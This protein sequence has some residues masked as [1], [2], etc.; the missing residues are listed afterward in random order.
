[1]RYCLF[2]L[3]LLLFVV[4]GLAGSGCKPSTSTDRQS[5][6]PPEAPNLLEESAGDLLEE[7]WAAHFIHGSK[8]GHRH[9]RVFRV[10]APDAPLLQIVSVDRLELRRF[11]N[12]VVQQLTTASLETDD[13]QIQALAYRL[14]DGKSVSQ[15]IGAVTSGHLVL[16]R[17]AHDADEK[18]RYVWSDEQRGIFAVQRS[19]RRQP[20]KPGEKRT[21][22]GFL[23]L[24]DQAVEFHL[25]ALTDESV[26]IGDERR[27]LLRIEAVDP[28]ADRWQIPTI[29]WADQSGRV[30]KQQEAFLNRE[31]V[32]VDEAEANRPND[33]VRVDLGVDGGVPV[34]SP[35]P[36]A[37]QV[38]Y[39][40][41]RVQVSGLTPQQ[42]FPTGLSQ[43]VLPAEEGV[44][45]VTVRQVLPDVPGVVDVDI[46]PPEPE[47]LAPNA[48]IQS[49]NPRIRAIADSV[50]GS[51]EDPWF[52]AQLL[53]HHVHGRLSKTDFSQVFSSAAEVAEQRRGDC[54]EHAVL[55]AAVC[56]ARQIPARVT[57]GLLYSADTR[58][59]LYHMWNEVWIKDRWIPLDA[60][61][62]RGSIGGC[63]LK[64][65]DSNLAHESAYGL[66]APV[67]YLMD[68]IQIDVVAAQPN[69][70]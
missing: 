9:T 40:V 69:V 1:M 66:V 23:P 63:H 8:V 31:T 14:D 35:I 55:L 42:V 10:G 13:G 21:V 64:L 3:S 12:R 17:T 39:A 32:V 49:D 19:L 59:F 18:I 37:S 5:P 7:S 28:R 51:V 44:A 53:E 70:P 11:G 67:I 41:Y 54:S 38:N 33:L 65:R 48:L 15:A 46:T 24:F 27:N 2:L 57:V 36:N 58:R 30:L 16:T 6:H 61:L 43:R 29:Y 56:R 45:L 62:G 50:A 68:R 60:T 4:G 22:Q 25:E 47:D 26:E 20:M 34:D 52:A